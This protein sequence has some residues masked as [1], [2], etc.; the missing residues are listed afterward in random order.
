MADFL[1]GTL[2]GGAGGAWGAASAALDGGPALGVQGREAGSSRFAGLLRAAA[3]G[4]DAPTAPEK[5]RAAA[6]QFVAIAL[7]QPLLKQLR[8]TSTAAPPFAP[9]E[10]EKQFQ[11]L[12]DAEIA[13][14][15]VKAAHFPLVDRLAEQLT[16]RP[17]SKQTAGK[18]VQPS[19]EVTG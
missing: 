9:T 14:R 19:T 7:V 1:N 2:T 10:G 5:A 11:G 13:Q 18:A 17:Q 4:G 3:P 15:M 12:Y 16:R 8:E 6:E